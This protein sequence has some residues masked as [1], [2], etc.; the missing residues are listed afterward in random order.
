VPVGGDV[1]L[2]ELVRRFLRLLLARV[3]LD[4]LDFKASHSCFVVVSPRR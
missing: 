1:M 2:L 4:G 3:G